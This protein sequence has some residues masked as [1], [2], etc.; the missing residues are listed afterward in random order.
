[1]PILHSFEVN[2]L[3]YEDGDEV[4]IMMMGTRMDKESLEHNYEDDITLIICHNFSLTL[5]PPIKPKD[6]ELSLRAAKE[7]EDNEVLDKVDL[8]SVMDSEILVVLDLFP[9]GILTSG[10][11][12]T[13]LV[14]VDYA[15]TVFLR[16]VATD[17]FTVRLSSLVLIVTGFEKSLDTLFVVTDFDFEKSFFARKFE[18]VAGLPKTDC[19]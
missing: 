8:L 10:L 4:K 15:A 7:L 11:T 17:W 14:L 16:G 12:F 1:M 18:K 3:E 13:V 19:L 9:R 6:T 2:K 5:N